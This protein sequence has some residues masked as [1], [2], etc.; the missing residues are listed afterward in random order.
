MKIVWILVILIIIGVAV[1]AIRKRIGDEAGNKEKE[2]DVKEAEVKDQT[3]QAISAGYAQTF[4]Q[5]VEDVYS[6]K[7]SS[8]QAFEMIRT[9]NKLSEEDKARLEFEAIMQEWWPNRAKFRGNALQYS[10]AFNDTGII[11]KVYLSSDGRE[12]STSNNKYYDTY[13]VDVIVKKAEWPWQKD[14]TKKGFVLKSNEVTDMT[15]SAEPKTW[16]IYEVGKKRE[17]FPL[18]SQNSYALLGFYDVDALF[19]KQKFWSQNLRLKEL[20]TKYPWVSQDI[21]VQAVLNSTNL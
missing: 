10:K 12:L 3:Q 1:F 18:K 20:Q 11:R 2:S 21:R 16:D 8:G 6:G 5:K 4:Q 14:Q 9:D 13:D 19:D 15:T 7:I 17:I